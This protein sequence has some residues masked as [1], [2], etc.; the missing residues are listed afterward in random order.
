MKRTKLFLIAMLGAVSIGSSA[1]ILLAPELRAE[2]PESSMK[3]VN[4]LCYTGDTQCQSFDHSAC[5][6]PGSG[7]CYIT[8]C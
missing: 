3:C 4:E 7:F 5:H 6:D 8:Y 2:S 1:L